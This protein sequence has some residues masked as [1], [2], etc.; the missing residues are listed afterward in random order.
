M[1][2]SEKIQLRTWLDT[3]SAHGRTSFTKKEASK[4]LGVNS[5]ALNWSLYRQTK[6]GVIAK[7]KSGFYVIVDPPHRTL[8]CLPPEWI[9][10][11]LMA[12]MD[13]PYYV[14][15]LSAAVNHGASHQAVQELQV[16]VPNKRTGLRSIICGKV[17]IR[18]MRKKTFKS[19]AIVDFKTPTGNIKISDP[20][21]TALDLVF[22]S[23]SAGGLD[24]VATVLKD[25]A[26]MMDA[27]KLK[28]TIKS[29]GDQLTARRLGYILQ[30]LKLKEL[31]QACLSKSNYPQRLLDPG[32]HASPEVDAT[33][34]LVI[35][36]QL[37]PDL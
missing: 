26:E 14:G 1:K 15:G 27:Q 31:S 9:I 28:Q 29:H 3:L 36:H 20:E 6:A 32:S 10:S 33:W 19:A 22:F 21:T 7:P 30:Y 8:G 16:V 4:A 24:N 13:L 11:D 12:Y 18:F 17:R 35:N 2:T 23:K 37:D 5:A 34:N 25:L